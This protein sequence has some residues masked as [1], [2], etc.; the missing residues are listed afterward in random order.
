ME[1]SIGADLT[2]DMGVQ[3]KPPNILVGEAVLRLGQI[4]TKGFQI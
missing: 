3:L 2:R 1:K 4:K